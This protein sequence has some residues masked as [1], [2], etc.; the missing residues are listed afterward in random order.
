MNTEPTY[1]EYYI[2]WQYD[3]VTTHLCLL[4][5]L[6]PRA[7]KQVDILIFKNQALQII[8]LKY[9]VYETS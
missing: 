7:I 4:N 8:Y 2:L 6:K 3:L 9:H 1:V 5:G